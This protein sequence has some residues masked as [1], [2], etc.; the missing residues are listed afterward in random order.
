VDATLTQLLDTMPAELVGSLEL[1]SIPHWTDDAL[2]VALME[3]FGATNGGT[4]QALGELKAL[5][6]VSPHGHDSWRVVEPIAS[7]LRARV[8]RNVALALDVNEFLATWLASCEKQLPSDEPRARE[9]QWRSIY[10]RAVVDPGPALG[11]LDR[12]MSSALPTRRHSDLRAAL[13][14]TQ[15]RQPWLHEFEAEVTFVEG[16][17]AYNTNDDETAERCFAAVWESNTDHRRRIVAGHLLGV[18][19]S[20]RSAW[21]EAE[22]I[23]RETV[24][25]AHEMGDVKGE[26]VTLT[27]L[28]RLLARQGGE[29]RLEVADGVLRYA[30]DLSSGDASAFGAGDT[31]NRAMLLSTLGGVLSQRGG[32]R[33]LQEAEEHL[34]ESLA[35]APM[36]LRS[37]IID[38]FANVLSRLGGARR[39]RTAE[40]VLREYVESPDTKDQDAAI[41]L[42]TLVNVMLRSKRSD[43]TEAQR[44]IQRSIDLGRASGKKRHEAMAS[45]TASRVAE[46]RGDF[47]AAI[48]LMRRVLKLN[49]ELGLDEN[50][51]QSRRRLRSL[52][53]RVR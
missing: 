34:L 37:S 47:P 16:Q 32:T 52:E 50:I 18:I 26:A 51:R 15:V 3:R 35:I 38:R 9:L 8:E 21:V 20:K 17:Y 45:Y 12:F 46:Q 41:K 43:L 49:E 14:L 6:F 39:L 31:Y 24:A 22:T 28:A 11:Q 40:R 27:T 48:R 30:L 7:A 2:A 53:R 29:E 42:N 33:R 23:L 19:R 36:M 10:H 4:R 44:L 25:L 5:P 13:E 1:V